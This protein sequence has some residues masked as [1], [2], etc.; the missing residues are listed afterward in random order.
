MVIPYFMFSV[1]S[2]LTRV[3]ILPRYYTNILKYPVLQALRYY[4]NSTTILEVD[5]SG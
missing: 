1:K 2:E 3:N 4:F 5:V